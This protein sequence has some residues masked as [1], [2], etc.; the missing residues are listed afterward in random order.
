M[1]R[2]IPRQPLLN[3]DAMRAAFIQ[4]FQWTKSKGDTTNNL[5]HVKHIRDNPWKNSMNEVWRQRQK[6]ILHLDNIDMVYDN[7]MWSAI[8]EPL[9]T[10]AVITCALYLLFLGTTFYNHVFSWLGLCPLRCSSPECWLPTIIPH[11]HMSIH[12]LFF[13]LSTFSACIACASTIYLKHIRIRQTCVMF[14]QLIN[15]GPHPMW[16]IPPLCMRMWLAMQ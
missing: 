8:F 14:L 10:M 11:A 2:S 6:F 7:D 3:W 1:V 9:L 15:C 16:C 13:V 4:W 12:L 5:S